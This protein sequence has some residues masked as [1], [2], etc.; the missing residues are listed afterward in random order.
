MLANHWAATHLATDVELDPYVDPMVLVE[1]GP[2][3]YAE[4]VGRSVDGWDAL[5]ELIAD[6]D[7][8]VTAATNLCPCGDRSPAA[9]DPAIA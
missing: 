1:L 9:P 4:L 2:G 7:P 6:H 3:A 8:R 5:I